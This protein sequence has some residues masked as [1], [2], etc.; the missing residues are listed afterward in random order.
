MHIL[1]PKI[2]RKE[3]DIYKS[4]P[5]VKARADVNIVNGIHKKKTKLTHR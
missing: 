1:K 2:N 4:I 5:K 3:E